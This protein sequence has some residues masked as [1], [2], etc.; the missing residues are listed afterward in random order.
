MS[1]PAATSRAGKKI[2]EIPSE[3]M[4][5]ESLFS[6]FRRHS[7]FRRHFSIVNNPL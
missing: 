3:Q 5:S 4:P 6:G 1:R 2:L 7:S